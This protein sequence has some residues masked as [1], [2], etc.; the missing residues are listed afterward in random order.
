MKTATKPKPPA[1]PRAGED[2]RTDG[3]VL[4]QLAALKRLSVNQLKV[5]WK[6]LFAG[7]WKQKVFDPG[8]LEHL[9]L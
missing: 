3:T 8:H 7:H 2:A 5:K 6:D 4:A 9:G 1:L